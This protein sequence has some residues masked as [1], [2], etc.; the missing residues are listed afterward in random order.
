MPQRHRLGCSGGAGGELQQCDVGVVLSRIGWWAGLSLATSH[1]NSVPTITGSPDSEKRCAS[2]G[3]VI[4]ATG[5]SAASW[6]T[7]SASAARGF[8]GV[9]TPPARHVP[10]SAA[11]VVASLGSI[12]ATTWPARSPDSVSSRPRR[13]ALATRSTL[14]TSASGV[15]TATAGRSSKSSARLTNQIPVEASSEIACRRT[16]AAPRSGRGGPTST[17][18]ASRLRGRRR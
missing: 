8:S 7:T 5:R 12:A 15:C 16:P 1:C 17:S 2:S 4:T 13:P 3:V 18:G 10:N 14:A 9:Y 11:M 6:L